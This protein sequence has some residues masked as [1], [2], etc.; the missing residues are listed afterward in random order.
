[1]RYDKLRPTDGL[2]AKARSLYATARAFGHHTETGAAAD[3]MSVDG[4]FV[5]SRARCWPQTEALKATIMMENNGLASAAAFKTKMLDVLL[6][7]YIDGP[8]KGGWYDAINANG[9]LAAPDM[10]SSTFY[11]L[12]CA[13]AEYLEN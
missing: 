6:T 3:T 11:H 1:M 12:Y 8:L 2:A 5:S 7:H 9:H 13:L 10:P 4:S